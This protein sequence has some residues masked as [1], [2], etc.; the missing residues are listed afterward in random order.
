MAPLLAISGATGYLGS[1][2]CGAFLDRGY[3]VIALKRSTSNVARLRPFMERLQVRDVDGAPNT[4]IF[5]RASRPLVV[6]HAA[7]SYGRRGETA[8][9]IFE[10]NL[11]FPLR[12]LRDAAGARARAFVNVDTV[13]P[14]D[15]NDYTR[16]KTEFRR[17]ALEE[18]RLEGMAF[19]N[20]RTGHMYGPGDDDTKFTTQ[21]IRNCAANVPSMELT[22]GLQ[23]RDF[24]YI[25]DAVEA[26]VVICRWALETRAPGGSFDLGLGTG[27]SVR[28]FA[29]L[30][31]R[32][33]GSKTR[34]LF[35]AIP[36]RAG[37]PMKCDIDPA[38]LAAI[39]WAP[40]FSLEEGLRRTIELEKSS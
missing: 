34:L 36:Y 8:A 33:A 24:V 3:E 40:R 31:H 27:V 38:P 15:V 17:R 9:E 7:T 10:A 19:V 29:E 26:F 13:L 16:S 20:V 32:I 6:L 12:L 35:G 18:E 2:L 14:A 11:H 25:D 37:D 22:H 30:A 23:E 4:A 5:D 21:V 39:G 1:R 28:R